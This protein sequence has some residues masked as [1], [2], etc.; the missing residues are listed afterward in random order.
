MKDVNKERCD[1]D[2]KLLKTK[3]KRWDD[4]SGEVCEIKAFEVF[5]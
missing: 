3:I 1:L 5:H 4:S 2:S